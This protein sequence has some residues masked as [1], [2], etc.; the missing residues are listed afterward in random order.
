MTLQP[1]RRKDKRGRRTGQAQIAPNIHSLANLTQSKGVF[2]LSEVMDV[3]VVYCR[4]GQCRDC[5]E[6][7]Q[8][9]VT[10]PTDP[11]H[12]IMNNSLKSYENSGFILNRTISAPSALMMMVL[13]ILYDTV[14]S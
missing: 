13:Y 6:E 5:K 10:V 14:L 4:V 3:I 1:K 8:I 7:E 9:G 2:L 11:R 12:G